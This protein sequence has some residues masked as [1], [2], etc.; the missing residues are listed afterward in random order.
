MR[1]HLRPLQT[2]QFGAPKFQKRFLSA[3]RSPLSDGSGSPKRRLEDHQKSPKMRHICTP[4]TGSLVRP[5]RLQIGHFVFFFCFPH[6]AWNPQ[7]Y[8]VFVHSMSYR[9]DFRRNVAPCTAVPAQE[10]AYSRSIAL[11]LWKGS[12]DIHSV[13]RGKH[14]HAIAYHLGVVYYPLRIWSRSGLLRYNRLWAFHEM[15]TLRIMLWVLSIKTRLLFLWECTRHEHHLKI[16]V[17]NSSYNGY[18]CRPITWQD[19]CNKMC[20]PWWSEHLRL[21]RLR[22]DTRMK[23][24]DFEPNFNIQRKPMEIRVP[25]SRTKH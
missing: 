8:S 25:Y 24:H 9:Q 10:P 16:E 6:F 19:H 2:S 20:V 13:P 14:L 3:E 18:Q 4:W 15:L 1:A 11:V 5:E 7:F 22:T 12:V 17:V 21:C 23:L